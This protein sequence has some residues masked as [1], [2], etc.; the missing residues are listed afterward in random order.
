[1]VT[2]G[3]RIADSFVTLF[4]RQ[5]DKETLSDFERD[6]FTRA[7][8]TGRIDP[9]DYEEAHRR[10][11]LCL[12]DAGVELTYSKGSDGTYLIINPST[13]PWSED[14]FESIDYSCYH[15]VLPNVEALFH[16][17]QNNPDLLADSR[18]VAVR[19]LLK[20]GL[21]PS[22]YSVDDFGRDAD[23]VSPYEPPFMNAPFDGQDPVAVQCLRGAGYF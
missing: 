6:V 23:G 2:P 16:L 21:V 9:A 4:Q 19:C 12:R 20:A 5:L 10:Y 3:A 17:Q 14:E 13:G 8:A 7:V 11:D 15:G 1:M 18:E 22:S